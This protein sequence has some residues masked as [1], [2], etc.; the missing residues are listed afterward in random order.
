MNLSDWKWLFV[1]GAISVAG[2]GNDRAV[3]PRKDER[4]GKVNVDIRDGV[5]VDV[6]RGDGKSGGVDVEVRDGKVNVDIK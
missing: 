6:R 3:E 4:P 2:C 5:D 1:S